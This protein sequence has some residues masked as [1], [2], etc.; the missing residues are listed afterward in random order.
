[1]V[2]CFSPR[3]LPPDGGL[4]LS[5]IRVEA[6]SIRQ[7]SVS[8][9]KTRKRLMRPTSSTRKREFAPCRAR[10]RKP[11]NGD[12]CTMRKE[13]R[14]EKR[15]GF[16]PLYLIQGKSPNLFSYQGHCRRAGRV[17]PEKLIPFRAINAVKRGLASSTGSAYKKG[18]GT[19]LEHHPDRHGA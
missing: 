19:A 6:R 18:A 13:G 4:C 7:R 14:Q 17:F 15:Y 16:Y 12:W 1:M 11:R 8:S 2:T 5:Y 3:R 10:R 9:A